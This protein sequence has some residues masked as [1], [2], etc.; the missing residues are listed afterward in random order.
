MHVVAQPRCGAMF[1]FA[2]INV[3]CPTLALAVV[4]SCAPAQ[5]APPSAGAPARIADPVA[6]PNLSIDGGNS[7]ATQQPVVLSGILTGAD[8]HADLEY[9]VDNGRTWS[10]L[11]VNRNGETFTAI[12]GGLGDGYHRVQLRVRQAPGI[13]AQ[14]SLFAVGRAI[15]VQPGHSSATAGTPVDVAGLTSFQTAKFTWHYAGQ[16][17][18]AM[19]GLS[20][21]ST[22]RPGPWSG[23][24]QAPAKP[25]HYVILV[26]DNDGSASTDFS[27]TVMPSATPALT[28]DPFIYDQS[29]HEAA[30]T[31]A[32]EY[33]GGRPSALDYRVDTADWRTDG[34]AAIADDGTWM[35]VLPPQQATGAYHTIAVRWSG[36][37]AAQTARAG[38][39]Y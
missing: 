17:R 32:G 6:R 19:L 13:Q 7:T 20:I 30:L 5:A 23:I 22:V 18:G 2:E 12:I 21:G 16:Q 35:L 14:T 33:D 37:P 36:V 34:I 25:G 39:Q 28:M 26:E 8:G 10:P 24:M 4:L 1:K 15:F 38:V 11:A 29:H 27:L 31:L 9:D 3:L